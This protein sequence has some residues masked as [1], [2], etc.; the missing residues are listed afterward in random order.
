M[1][2]LTWGHNDKRIFVA[3]GAQV[4]TLITYQEFDF[5]LPI[6]EFLDEILRN[7]YLIGEIIKFYI[8]SRHFV[9]FV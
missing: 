6:S 2:A 7:F 4:Q 1:S 3:T 9:K 5:F 8:I